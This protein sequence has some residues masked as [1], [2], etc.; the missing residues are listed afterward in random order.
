MSKFN[1]EFKV[2]PETLEKP[3]TDLFPSFKN[4]LVRGEPGGYVMPFGFTTEIAK[5]IYEMQA[6]E[7][8]VWITTF[9]K[10]GILKFIC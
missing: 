8:D 10:S 5:V 4:G 7:D 6:R 2:I 9:L 3:F 1:V